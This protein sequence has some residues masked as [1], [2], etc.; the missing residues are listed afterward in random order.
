MFDPLSELPV[1]ER[2]FEE[3]PHPG[4]LQIEQFTETLNVYP[5]R[6]NYPPVSTHNVK[7]WFKNRR[8]KCKY[9]RVKRKCFIKFIKNVLIYLEKIFF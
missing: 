7:I 8:A 1:L 2:W 6:Q 9:V 4:W 3:N 5:Y